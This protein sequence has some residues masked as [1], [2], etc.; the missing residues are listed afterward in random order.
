MLHSRRGAKTFAG[1]LQVGSF[2]KKEVAALLC[3]LLESSEKRTGAGKQDLAFTFTGGI[4]G[5]GKSLRRD[6]ARDGRLR[7][8]ESRMKHPGANAA[9]TIAD[10]LVLSHA[11][12]CVFENA[13]DAV[14]SA[15]G[16]EKNYIGFFK[17]GH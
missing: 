15:V 5:L 2:V 4:S 13:P 1:E 8:M 6:A 9:Q 17:L 14:K 12:G 16:S 11:L 10:Q 3:L 7:D